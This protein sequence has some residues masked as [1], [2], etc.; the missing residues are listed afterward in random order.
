MFVKNNETS[1]QM[2]IRSVLP[3]VSEVVVL[4][5]GS[6]DNTVQLCKD[7]G[8]FVYRCGFTNFGEIRTLAFQLS[9]TPYVL[10]LDS[11]EAILP[12]DLPKVKNMVIKMDKENFDLVNLPRRRW[13]ELDMAT[14]VEPEAYPDYQSRL[15]RNC[16][17]IYFA[18]RVHEVARGMKRAYDCKDDGPC[19]QH[20]QDTFKS[21]DALKERNEMYVRLFNEDI[22]AGVKHDGVA[23][24]EVDL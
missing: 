6:T 20:F 22:E 10:M 13:A 11:D 8:A 2:A 16:R 14:E 21:G 9:S 15:L 3:I 19:I 18:R 5:T 7:L 12:E 24:S 4:D 17:H 23:V 1:V